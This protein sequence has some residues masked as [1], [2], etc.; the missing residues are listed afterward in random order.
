M[1]VSSSQ[2]QDSD[3]SL[4]RANKL[5]LLERLADDLAHEIKN[6]LHSLVINLEVLKRRIARVPDSQASDMLRYVGV[7]DGEL[8]RVNRRIE[9][10]LRLVRPGRRT[11]EVPLTE[12]LEDLIDLIEFEGSRRKVTVR[13]QQEPLASR[14][15]LPVD[16]ARQIVLNLVLAVLDR[17]P[18][19]PRSPCG[20]R[21]TAPTRCSSSRAMPTSPTRRATP[22]PGPIPASPRPA[23]SA[24]ALASSCCCPTPMKLSRRPSVLR[25]PE[26]K[27]P[28]RWAACD[29]VAG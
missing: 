16:A 1:N 3:A 10:L 23:P 9:L 7:L 22:L 11:D 25:C 15:R 8:T 29:C 14:V 5:D 19:A 4:V 12:V 6:P 13:L 2:F 27:R 26:R 21:A 24:M 28:T 17:C 18:R 20:P